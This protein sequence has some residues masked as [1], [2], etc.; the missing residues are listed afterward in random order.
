MD[1]FRRWQHE[2]RVQVQ[3]LIDELEALKVSQKTP[4]KQRDEVTA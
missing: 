1:V 4:N 3:P 2:L